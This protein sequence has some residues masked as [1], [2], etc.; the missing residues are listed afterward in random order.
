MAFAATW[1]W[2]KLFA[3]LLM[4]AS[5]TATA[6]DRRN[7]SREADLQY[8]TRIALGSESFTVHPWKSQLTVL[9]SA[10]SAD[11]EGWRLETHGERHV[12]LDGQ[13]QPVR[14]FP[15]RLDFRVTA[16]TLTRLF[17]SMPFPL[18]ASLDTNDYL[19]QLRFRMKVF[20]G[21]RQRTIEPEEVTLIG[22]PKDIPFDERIFHVSFDLD[23]IP[24]EDRIVLEVVAPSGQRLCKFHL[25]LN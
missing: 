4:A 8:H 17:G 10:E 3:V 11:F 18:N 5:L 9:A 23:R 13:G 24:L 16:G 15:T 21:L 2:K 25:D 12:L 1:G 14:F 7:F 22:V 6:A 19:L 20:H